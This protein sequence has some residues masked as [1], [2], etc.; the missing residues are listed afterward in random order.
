MPKYK[1]VFSI[2]VPVSALCSVEVE[3]FNEDIAED[4]AAALVKHLSVKSNTFSLQ[5][6]KTGAFVQGVVEINENSDLKIGH[7]SINKL[8]G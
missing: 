7:A 6:S 4:L 2:T 8:G 5:C 3:A 1:N